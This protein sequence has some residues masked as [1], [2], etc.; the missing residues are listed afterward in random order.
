MTLSR[1]LMDHLRV[2]FIVAVWGLWLST[3]AT[4]AQETTTPDSSSTETAASS[5]PDSSD[6]ANPDKKPST[7]NPNRVRKGPPPGLPQDGREYVPVGQISL[8]IIPLVNRAREYAPLPVQMKVFNN[9][10]QLLTGDLVV[11]AKEGTTTMTTLFHWRKEF[12]FVEDEQSFRLLLPLQIYHASSGQI[13]LQFFLETDTRRYDLDIHPLQVP[14]YGTQ[15]FTIGACVPRFD[16]FDVRG[17][18]FRRWS[19]ELEEWLSFKSLLT[20]TG[21]EQFVFQARAPRTLYSEFE[22]ALLPEQPIE[23]TTF[24]ILVMSDQIAGEINDR[25]F[26]A[27]RQ[28][29]RAGGNLLVVLPA[30]VDAT[31]VERL[32]QLAIFESE[33]EQF[34]ANVDG[35][36]IRGEE[37]QP[38][39]TLPIL[40]QHELGRVAM[41]Q[42]ALIDKPEE[43]EADRLETYLF[44]WRIREQI[45]SQLWDLGVYQIPITRGQYSDYIQSR[46]NR[47]S[48]QD[49]SVYTLPAE[50]QSRS[51]EEQL[52]N[53]LLRQAE[54]SDGY[55]DSN[56]EIWLSDGTALSFLL[57]DGFQVVPTFVI[58]GILIAYL[59]AVGPGD[60]LL[61]G[62]LR[63]RKWTW[64]T[65]PLITLVFTWFTMN[66]I[67]AYMKVDNPERKL[68]VTDIGANG[69]V[70]RRSTFS[71][72]V[73]AQPNLEQ[74]VYNQELVGPGMTSDS[75]LLDPT[76]VRYARTTT[77]REVIPPTYS[78][79]LNGEYELSQPLRKWSPQTY[80]GFAIPS[81]EESTDTELWQHHPQFWNELDGLSNSELAE[82]NSRIKKHFPESAEVEV[83]QNEIAQ[84]LRGRFSTARTPAAALMKQIDWTRQW[85]E[86]LFLES[87][88]PQP[89]YFG[90]N[91][92]VG[93]TDYPGVKVVRVMWQEE[94]N[95][96]VERRLF[97]DETA[98]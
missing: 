20:Y 42:S 79:S 59:L 25:Q 89:G 66:R 43:H 80:I 26:H 7:A 6:Q 30:E 85:D 54:L 46:Y 72:I 94:G 95:L 9:S 55:A 84:Q 11:T 52:R 5:E 96:Y 41:I 38:L 62:Q 31:L 40:R 87:R 67:N 61:L 97:I 63:K 76:M 18:E 86:F 70:L 34:Y 73:S 13:E 56:P 39:D 71:C 90:A 74:T 23:Y 17:T 53:E 35:K 10:G 58:M 32:N 60:Y 92:V 65:F 12:T 24:D 83:V 3:A 68:V 51:P 69:E 88:A 4:S 57:P 28:W 81:P 45:A 27:I 15:S 21:D 16:S 48:Y 33:S 82:L 19:R 98:E 2:A 44:L 47:Q 77:Q 8:E 78:G 49:P 50:E 1:L 36:L 93:D 29:V 64:L 37:D 14:L 91:Q 22:V 75:M